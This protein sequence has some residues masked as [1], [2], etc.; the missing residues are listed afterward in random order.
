MNSGEFVVGGE[1]HEGDGDLRYRVPIWSEAI[2]QP[3]EIRQI[4]GV[5]I[6][7]DG[8]GEFDLTS[9][10]MRECQETDHGAAGLLLAFSRQQRFEDAGISAMWEQLI[11]IDQIEESHR[12]PAQ[13]VDDVMVVDHMAMLAGPLR[14]S[15][16]PQG[17]QLRRAEKAFEPVIIEADIEAVADQARGNAIE[18]APQ[19]EAATRCNEHAHFLVVGGSPLGERPQRGALDLDALAVSGM[20]RPITSSMKRR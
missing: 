17:Q 7:I 15:A 8:V 18:H 12:L 20:R 10:I 5:K 2:S 6:G 14:R 3:I 13:R 9:A 16:T 4:A 11:A 19:N 1:W